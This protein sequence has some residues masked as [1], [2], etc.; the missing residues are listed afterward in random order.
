MAKWSLPTGRRFLAPG[1]AA[2][3]L[4][5]LGVVVILELSSRADG[6]LAMDGH[7]KV[8]FPLQN[9]QT[10]TWGMV[11]PTN[12]TISDITIDSIEA[13]NPQGIEIVGMFV[14]NPDVDGGVGSD[15][16]FPPARIHPSQVAGAVI[17]SIGSATPHLQLLVGVRLDDANEGTIES[18]RVRYQFDGNRYEVVLPFALRVF[19]AS[20]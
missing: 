20:D 7:V 2:I 14:N 18:I 12:P 1:A 13:V 11:L 6:P 9:D 3:L 10:G 17:G 5:V 15:D 4:V 16:V 19:K 8:E